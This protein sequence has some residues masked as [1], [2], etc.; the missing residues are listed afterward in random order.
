MEEYFFSTG[1]ELQ[2][3][4]TAGHRSG[5]WT[6]YDHRGKVKDVRLY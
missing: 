4:F 6:Y 5:K 2:D 1:I 3:D